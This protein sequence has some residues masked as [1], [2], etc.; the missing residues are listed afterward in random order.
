MMS[1]TLKRSAL[2]KG[3]VT[4][5]SRSRIAS[6]SAAGSADASISDFYA[7]SSPPAIGSEPQSPEGQQ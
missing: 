1:S 4:L 2:R 7:T 3:E 5:A 6:S